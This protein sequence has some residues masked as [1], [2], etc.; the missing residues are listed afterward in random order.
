MIKPSEVG[1]MGW[2]GVQRL[3]GAREEVGVGEVRCVAGVRCGREGVRRDGHM[4]GMAAQ[5][6]GWLHQQ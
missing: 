5:L 3:T 4:E 2:G 1:W 6:A